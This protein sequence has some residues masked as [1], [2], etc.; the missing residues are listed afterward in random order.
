MNDNLGSAAASIFKE[1]SGR[2]TGR[3]NFTYDAGKL[4]N[5]SEAE[6]VD[7]CDTANDLYLALCR[8]FGFKARFARD[9]TIKDE[10]DTTPMV[11]AE[12]AVEQNVANETADCCTLDRVDRE[13][14]AEKTPSPRDPINVVFTDD[15]A[16]VRGASVQ[17][18]RGY[19][20][21]RTDEMVRRGDLFRAPLGSI[22]AANSTI[23]KLVHDVSSR[24][25]A[26]ILC[27][28]RK[29]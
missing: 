26:Q 10:V 15:I 8:E 11:G 7:L 18:P 3:F 22:F 20:V 28:F 14:F 12:S 16:I 1:T 13:L 17:I 23:G 21:L 4:R 9:A 2:L 25:N 24:E 19:R 29:S 27:F 5:L 6:K